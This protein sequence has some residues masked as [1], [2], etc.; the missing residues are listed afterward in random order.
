FAAR[1]ALITATKIVLAN[2]LKVLGISSP[3]RM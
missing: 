1:I 2:G 3:E